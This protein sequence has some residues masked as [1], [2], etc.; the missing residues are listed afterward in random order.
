MKS[1]LNPRSAAAPRE[2][3]RVEPLLRGRKDHR[4]ALARDLDLFDVEAEVLGQA[5]GLRIAGAKHLGELAHGRSRV[6]L[7]IYV[8]LRHAIR[9][10]SHSEHLLV[11]A[12]C[13]NA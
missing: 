6:Y 4:I 9:K 12:A 13:P 10:L 7:S 1:A 3:Q 8:R 5:D 2:A 11:L